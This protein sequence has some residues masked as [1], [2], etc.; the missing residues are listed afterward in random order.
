MF[1]IGST[2]IDDLARGAALLGTGGGGNPGIGR[3]LAI[4][5][6]GP[7]GRITVLDPEDLEDDAVVIPTALI[8]AP[9]VLLEQLPNGSEPARALAALERFARVKATATMPIECGGVNSMVPLLV[10]AQRGLPVVDADG[11][12]RAFPE[13]QMETFGVYGVSG[14]PLAIVDKHGRS[15]IVDTGTDNHELERLARA[16]TIQMGGVAYIAEYLMSGAEVKR[17]AVPRTL[18]TAIAL[19]QAMREGRDRKDSPFEALQDALVSTPYGDGIVLFEG[20]VV[21]I[22]RRVVDGFTRG[23]ARIDSLTGDER[24]EIGFQNEYLTLTVDGESRASVP[25][26]ITILQLETGEPITV[27]ALRYAQRVCV[28][29]IGAPEIMRT[30]AALETFGPEAF[31]IEIPYQR[32]E[33]L[34]A[35]V[36]RV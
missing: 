24:A 2:E 10:A 22:D 30:P 15:A 5:A 29:G 11:M 31:G 8:G 27:E 36:V 14:S 25:D 7:A 28:F 3:L 26:L 1:T 33:E 23:T 18:S 19:G 16:L 12:G 17:T 21:D 32:L 6:L 35:P 34:S 13:L 4:S 9:S 20:K